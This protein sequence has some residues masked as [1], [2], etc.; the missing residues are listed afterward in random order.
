MQE[1]L[2][3]YQKTKQ[4]EAIGARWATWWRRLAPPW[5]RPAWHFKCHLTNPLEMAKKHIS[6][7][8]P[9]LITSRCM[10]KGRKEASHGLLTHH[11]VCHSS[12]GQNTSIPTLYYTPRGPT[13]KEK[14]PLHS[15]TPASTLHTPPGAPQ[16]LHHLSFGHMQGNT[17][18][19]NMVHPF[20]V[21][22]LAV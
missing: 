9:P 20:M 19:S 5:C 14:G 22:S 2:Q 1:N 6:K 12:N 15:G 16:W 8:S 21:V 3:K 11:V 13:L 10:I 18:R 17:L 7:P 4:L